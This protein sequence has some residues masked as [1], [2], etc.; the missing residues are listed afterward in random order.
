MCW[1]RMSFHCHLISI[2][3]RPCIHTCH[4]ALGNSALTPYKL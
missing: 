4:V 3:Q 2:E 1:R